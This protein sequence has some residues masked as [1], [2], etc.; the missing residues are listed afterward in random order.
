MCHDEI[1]SVPSKKQGTR[2][3]ADSAKDAVQVDETVRVPQDSIN[4]LE[5][6]GIDL[7]IDKNLS[8]RWRR[9]LIK[10]S[11]LAQLLLKL[12]SGI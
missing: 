4:G 3:S 1:V 10:P 7:G 6:K 9:Q 12:L 2:A 5:F 11:E 8:W